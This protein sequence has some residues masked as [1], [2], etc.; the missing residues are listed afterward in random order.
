MASPRDEGVLIIG[1]GMSF[2][3]LRAFGDKRV[4]GASDA[5]GEKLYSELVLETVISGFGFAA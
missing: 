3:D 5:P 4:T 2:H 1:S